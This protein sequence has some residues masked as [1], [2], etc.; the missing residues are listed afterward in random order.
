MALHPPRL[1]KAPPRR[2]GR[3]RNAAGDQRGRLLD[4]AAKLFAQRGIAA[5]PLA[6]VARSARVTP[7]MLHYYF[8]AREQLLDAIVE[9][10]L[11]PFTA[12][13]AAQIAAAGRDPHRL[14][15]GVV[16]TFF[17]I[18]AANPWLPQLWVHEVLREGGLLRERIIGRV[19]GRT[20]PALAAFFAGAQKRG[21]LGRELDPRLL[22]VSL[23]GLTL[24]P[25]AAA[26]IWRRLFAAD[27]I[28]PEEL[29][30]H[31]LALLDH[32]LGGRRG[33]RR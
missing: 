4:A 23:I 7:A 25:C 2:P 33:A 14:I 15:R 9:E 31:T 18:I 28:G 27:D 30:R 8:G 17:E 20:A 10:R 5:T 21:A 24:F 26:P 13:V 1:R 29:Q 12:K 16:E 11:A 32:G 19:A 22:M 6:A 3:P